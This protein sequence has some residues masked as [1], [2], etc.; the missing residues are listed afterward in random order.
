MF[1]SGVYKQTECPGFTYSFKYGA[2]VLQLCAPI[3]VGVVVLD[4]VR[5]QICGATMHAVSVL[6]SRPSS[7]RAA[8]TPDEPSVET[9]AR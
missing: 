6:T 1:M 3:K 9:S 4:G 2:A 7:M 8:Q 5:F